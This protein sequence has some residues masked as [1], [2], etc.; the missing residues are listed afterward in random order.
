MSLLSALPFLVSEMH[1]CQVKHA[2]VFTLVRSGSVF[3][4]HSSLATAKRSNCRVKLSQMNFV[5]LVKTF[6][7]FFSQ[8]QRCSGVHYFPMTVVL[9]VIQTKGLWINA[10]I[11]I[12]Y[13]FYRNS[14]Y[15]RTYSTN[16]LTKNEG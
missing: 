14:P 1:R 4:K 9:A 16:K 3:I 5:L 11:R 8:P 6:S 15:A 10:G 13:S 7:L 2:H 12:R